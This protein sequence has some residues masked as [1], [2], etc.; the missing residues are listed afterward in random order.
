[1]QLAGSLVWRAP[2]AQTALRALLWAGQ[3]E[4]QALREVT[5]PVWAPPEMRV[6]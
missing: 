2:S 5:Q 3:R 6:M 4:Q 1:V